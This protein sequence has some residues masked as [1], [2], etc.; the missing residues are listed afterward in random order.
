MLH[1]APNRFVFLLL[2]SLLIGPLW[3][4]DEGVLDQT[5][6]VTDPTEARPLIHAHAHNDYNHERPLFDALRN[7]FCSVEADVFLIDGD[8]LVGH[9]LA[10]LNG[11][12]TLESLYLDPLLDRVREN[13][14]HVFSDGSDFTLLVDIK[15]DGD[16]T[17]V[18]LDKML[19]KYEEMLTRVKEGKVQKHAVTVIISGNRAWE[20]IALDP[21]RYAGVDGRLSDLTSNR[22][23]HLMPLI[24]DQWNLAFEWNGQGP[25]PDAEQAELRRIVHEARTHGRRVRFWATPDQPSPERTAVWSELLAAG[26][27]HIGTDDLNGLSAFLLS[28]MGATRD[29]RITVNSV[30][31]W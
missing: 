13:G 16:E 18:V 23:D 10:E 2:L 21:T 5:A 8:L 15:S 17:Y 26:V 24:S 28:Q 31:T 19:A 29:A 25:M 7:G 9:S 11:E 22:P 30:S 4:V 14:G 3:A 1:V 27:D 20:R 12:R 6:E